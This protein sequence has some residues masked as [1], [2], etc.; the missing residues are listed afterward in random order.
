MHACRANLAILYVRTQRDCGVTGALASQIVNCHLAHPIRYFQ[1]EWWLC[2]L[3][4]I[5]LVS[6]GV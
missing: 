3:G 5:L 1:W 4:L 6:P 2:V